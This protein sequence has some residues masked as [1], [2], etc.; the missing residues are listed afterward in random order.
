[1]AGGESIVFVQPH[2]F[3]KMQWRIE[4]LEEFE[5]A[6]IIYDNRFENAYYQGTNPRTQTQDQTVA[7]F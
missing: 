3:H 4:I 5:G 6:H 2:S 1:M 7:I